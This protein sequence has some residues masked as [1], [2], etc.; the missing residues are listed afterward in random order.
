MKGD[1]D[2]IKEMKEIK[3]GSKAAPELPDSVAGAN[4]EKEV[5]DKFR[6]VYSALYTSASSENEMLVLK[7]RLKEMIKADV[8][9]SAMEV[10]KVTSDSLMKLGKGDAILNGPDMLFDQLA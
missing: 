3:S 10:M 4:G 9:G 6:E 1:M 2:L 5:V 7:D 8:D